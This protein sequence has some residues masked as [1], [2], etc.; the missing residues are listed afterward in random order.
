VEPTELIER[1]RGSLL[2]LAAGD[3]LG[4]TLEFRQPGS[5]MPIDDI[6]GGGPFGLKAGEWTD[7]T[8]MALCLAESLIERR[9]FDPR[10]Q[11]ERYVRWY[12]HGHLS[13]TE[14]CFDIGNATRAALE[15]FERTHEPYAGSTDPRSAG[16]GSIMRLAPVPLFFAGSP[17]GAIARAADSSRTTHAATECV[18][19]CRYLAALIV[20]AVRGLSKDQLRSD[21]F[22]PEPRIWSAAPL[23]S[24]IAA[25]ASGSFRTRNP[26]DV[27]GTGYV[28]HSLEAALWAFYR[29]SS[30]RDGA[31]LA[32]NLG[33]DADTTG[34]VYGQLAGAFYG[35][36]GIP[37]TWRARLALGKRIAAFA[38]QLCAL[39]ESNG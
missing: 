26:P 16:N 5:F 31:L 21:H 11:M 12:R 1:Y 18:D 2:G 32:V 35:E 8:S 33:D 27:R 9:G 6:V 28:V 4:T 22:E 29:S 13:S 38:D 36:Q 39:T 17:R 19:G 30:F 34:A 24:K 15:S 14:R 10:D 7:D 23:A 20:G 37:K 3:A 25:I